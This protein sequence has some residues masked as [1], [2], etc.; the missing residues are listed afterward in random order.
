[1]HF[2]WLSGHWIFP[3]LQRILGPVEG[4]V[5]DVG[6]AAKP[7]ARWAPRAEQWFGIDVYDGPGVDAVVT[8]GARWPV[9]DASFDVVLCAAML[10]EVAELDDFVDEV[11]RVLAP[12]GVVV[13]TGPFFFN[14][15]KNTEYWRFT[16]EGIRRLLGG[17]LVVLEATSR[18]GIGSVLGVLLL[19]W[20]ETTMG[21]SRR[22]SIASM[23]LLPLRLLLA[24]V[25][26]TVAPLVDRIDRTGLFY[27]TTL[28]VAQKPSGADRVTDYLA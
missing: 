15:V 16:R 6:C 27:G 20:T 8:P 22:L 18:G 9:A 7:Y 26:N 12:G 23:M 3:D 19:N 4:R 13:A 11:E 28:V 25:V 21:L 1:M 5:L 17:R 14:E 10:A 24:A 2:Q